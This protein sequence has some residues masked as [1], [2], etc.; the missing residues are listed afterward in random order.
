MDHPKW[1]TL[2]PLEYR[3]HQLQGLGVVEP[4]PE[5]GITKE[6]GL[7]NGFPTHEGNSGS[8]GKQDVGVGEA[9]SQTNILLPPLLPAPA[10]P[11]P[12][13]L[14]RSVCMY[15]GTGAPRS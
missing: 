13:H 3:R 5:G 1:T 12:Y 6:G 11:C 14:T 15:R 2:I 8:E 4:P 9:F 10:S 7:V